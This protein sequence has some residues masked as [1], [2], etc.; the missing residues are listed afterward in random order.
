MNANDR[1]YWAPVAESNRK[2]EVR[3]IAASSSYKFAFP[4]KKRPD[5]RRAAGERG[6]GKRHAREL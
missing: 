6:V 3:R 4:K 5:S 1:A 2:D